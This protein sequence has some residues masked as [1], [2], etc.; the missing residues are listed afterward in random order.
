MWNRWLGRRL[1][2]ERVKLGVMQRKS[3]IMLVVNMFCGEC[4]P[5]ALSSHNDTQNKKSCLFYIC[6]MYLRTR[7]PVRNR[8]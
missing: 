3:K 6:E 8:I 5:V 4:Q 7:I 2:G 1:E